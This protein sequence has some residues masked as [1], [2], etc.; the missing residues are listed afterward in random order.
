MSEQTLS[1]DQQFLSLLTPLLPKDFI[2]YACWATC[3]IQ[4]NSQRK[5]FRQCQLADELISHY[6][7]IYCFTPTDKQIIFA[8][9]LLADAGKYFSDMHYA[10]IGYG[11]TY[12]YIQR[13]APNEFSAETVDQIARCVYDLRPRRRQPA[14]AIHSQ[15]TYLANQ[16]IPSARV[17]AGTLIKALL[18]S[19]IT[20][21]TLILDHTKNELLCQYGESGTYWYSYPDAGKQYFYDEWETTL[22]KLNDT[23]FLTELLQSIKRKHHERST[24]PRPDESL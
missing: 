10:R 11:L 14:T 2:R 6:Q 12:E 1:S 3:R 19:G 9:T 17:L 4:G 21:D 7:P 18:R 24:H 13:S 5:L 15:L 23:R 20:D 16:G 8:A 22:E